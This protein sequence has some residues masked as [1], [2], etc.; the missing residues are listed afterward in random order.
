MGVGKTTIAPLVA[1]QLRMDWADLDAMIAEAAGCSIPEIF[2]REGEVGFRVRESAAID[3][4]LDGP[5]QVV[6]L[7]GGTLHHGGNLKRLR[8]GFVVVALL[9]PFEELVRRIA[10]AASRPLWADAEALFTARAAGYHAADVTIDVEGRS[11]DQVA[12]DVVER[13]GC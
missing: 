8:Q 9:A 5:A 1:R 6:A 13:V 11:P 7:G 10:D 12:S 2:A 3:E 4:L